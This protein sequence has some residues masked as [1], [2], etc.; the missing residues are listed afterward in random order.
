MTDHIGRFILVSVLLLSL[1][2]RVAAQEVTAG[3]KVR[4]TAPS[5]GLDQH[6][7][8]LEWIRGDSLRVGGRTIPLDATTRV[9]IGR[10]VS[11]FVPFSLIGLAGGAAVT[12]IYCLI[13]CRSNDSDI[14][15]EG[16]MYLASLVSCNS[17]YRHK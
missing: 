12:A 4:V 16:Y 7:G 13:E 3:S 9:E 17:D 15:K 11:N 2:G 5:L 10:D 6:Q 14:S 1:P 8:I